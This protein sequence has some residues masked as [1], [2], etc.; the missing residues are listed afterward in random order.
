MVRLRKK[1]D[2]RL[3]KLEVYNKEYR[4]VRAVEHERLKQ[5]MSGAKAIDIILKHD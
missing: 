3:R 5:F 1:I 4:R 2:K